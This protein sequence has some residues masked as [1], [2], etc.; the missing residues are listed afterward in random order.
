M[1]RKIYAAGAQ[2]SDDDSQRH[3]GL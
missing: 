3:V 1:T 2:Y